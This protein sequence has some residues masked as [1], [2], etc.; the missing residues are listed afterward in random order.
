MAA[1]V[2]YP[3][4][5]ASYIC[6][7]CFYC[8][9]FNTL[10]GAGGAQIAKKPIIGLGTQK[11]PEVTYRTHVCMDGVRVEVQRKSFEYKRPGIP[12]GLKQART[13]ISGERKLMFPTSGI[14]Y[15]RED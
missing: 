7:V 9:H 12:Y 11:I 6:F 8:T 13:G 4:P 3:C 14:V 15:K 10:R 1:V 2:M 5:K